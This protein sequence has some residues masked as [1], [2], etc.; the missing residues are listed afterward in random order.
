MLVAPEE[1]TG[2]V[3]THRQRALAGEQVFQAEL[4]LTEQRA[5][6]I[7][8]R[9][10]VGLVV[11]TGAQVILQVLPHRRQVLDQRDVV[12]GQQ[13]LIGDTGQ[14]QNLRSVHG[15]GAE[16]HFL[17]RGEGAHHA[18]LGNGYPG[19]TLLVIEQHAVD[20]SI[21]LDGQVRP[22]QRRM[23]MG[24]T[25]GTALAVAGVDVVDARA[26]EFRPVEVVTVR[27]AQFIAALEEHIADR[28][29][30]ALHRGDADRAAATV[31]FAVA[32]RMVFQFSEVR[33]H[34]LETPAVVA[35]GRPV[36]EIVGLA[37][38]VDHRVDRARATLDLAARGID[39]AVVQ[40]FLRTAVVHPVK[41]RVVIHFGEADRNLEP[42][43][44][45]FPARFQQQHRVFSRGRKAIGQNAACGASA[46]DDVVVCHARLPRK[47]LYKKNRASLVG[48]VECNEAAIF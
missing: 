2:L 18:V 15:T 12:F 38:H 5:Q 31:V 28:M 22:A 34:I 4:E 32:Q 19:G 17:V 7:V 8:E 23:Q 43:R 27:I 16:D 46:S 9:R 20:Q 13:R 48:A 30:L 26:F 11:V 44:T 41:G 33:Q 14:L 47:S 24:K 37:A 29:G 36:I 6:F 1:T 42:Q 35:V 25:A 39:F 10:D 3:D 40:L 21:M 45:V